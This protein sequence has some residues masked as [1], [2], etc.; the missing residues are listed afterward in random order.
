MTASDQPGAIRQHHWAPYPP[1]VRVVEELAASKAR[2]LEI[3]PGQKPL[4]AATH[5]VDWQAWPELAGKPCETLD[6]NQ[7]RLPFGDQQFDFVYCR[8]TLE[9]LYNP[10]LA[11][12]EMDRVARAGFIET[13]SPIAEASRGV[14]WQS[15]PWRGYHHH[16]YFVWVDD[17]TLVFLPKYPVIEHITFG[18]LEPRLADWLNAHPLFWNTYYLWEG[19]LRWRLL[20]HDKDFS[21]LRDY[22]QQIEQA[23]QRSYDQTRRWGERYLG[24]Q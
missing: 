11:C 10:V 15:P 14:D 20:E 22:P 16:R 23:I 5:F 19:T 1:M 24:W 12:R 8:H 6:I 18:A 4:S 17:D 9:D 21:I 2:V 7:Q 3:G 13:P